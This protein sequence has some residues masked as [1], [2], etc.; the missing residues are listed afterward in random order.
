MN[1][2]IVKYFDLREISDEVLDNHLDI[3]KT[4]NNIDKN[5][6]NKSLSFIPDK[7]KKQSI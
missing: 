4:N 2:I 3:L 5:R 6:I 7:S 1:N